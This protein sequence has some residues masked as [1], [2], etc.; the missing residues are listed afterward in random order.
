MNDARIDRGSS[1]HR[2]LSIFVHLMIP[3]V[4]SIHSS[5]PAFGATRV[6]YGG[7]LKAFLAAEPSKIQRSVLDSAYV[8]AIA[9][10]IYEPLYRLRAD[11]TLEPVLA[12]LPPEVASGGRKIIVPLRPPQPTHEGG[13]LSPEDIRRALE[14]LA[15]AGSSAAFAFLPVRGGRARIEGRQAPLSVKVVEDRE[16]ASLVFELTTPYDAFPMLL[17][18]P[19]MLVGGPDD[20][21][22]GPFR[23]ASATGTAE[24]ANGSART[25]SPR[26]REGWTLLPFLL[27]REGRP[28]LDSIVIT[29]IASRFATTSVVEQRRAHVVLGVPE[30]A[31]QEVRMLDWPRGPAPQELITLSAGDGESRGRS[32]S[33]SDLAQLDA[34]IH[35]TRIVARYLGPAARATRTLRGTVT[36]T[37]PTSHPTANA[38]TEPGRAHRGEGGMP[39]RSTVA[40]PSNDAGPRTLLVPKDARFGQRLAERVQLDLIRAG[41]SA[42]ITRIS[43]EEA[44][45]RRRQRNYDFLLDTLYSAAPSEA[46]MAIRFHGLWQVAVAQGCP[47]A[48]DDASLRAFDEATE[49][50]RAVLVG[51]L[52]ERIRE[53]CRIIP[54]AT[55]P[56]GIFIRS[57]VSPISVDGGGRIA[58]ANATSLGLP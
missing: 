33:P 50:Q 2:S 49:A 4:F 53:A 6:P 28:F 17:A 7:Q 23:R 29:P 27:H 48:I 31:P 39:P 13:R 10:L 24:P 22:T 1:M 15:T 19:Q 12:S 20:T 34:A 14:D 44:T 16:G 11:G 3:F 35:R 37:S 55:S 46:P 56:P 32:P 57:D 30:R 51:A 52:D 40:N 5:R 8:V 21:G 43:R 25:A 18:V 41:I 45:Q 38:R 42:K 9:S 26:D 36:F 54:I 58:F 47:D